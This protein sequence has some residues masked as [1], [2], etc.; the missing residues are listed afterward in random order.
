VVNG[1]ST[2]SLRFAEPVLIHQITVR[3]A[4][5][6]RAPQ[7]VHLPALAEVRVQ[8]SFL[9]SATRTALG[10]PCSEDTDGLD[11]T[12]VRM[13]N[14]SYPSIHQT[15]GHLGSPLTCSLD[16]VTLTVIFTTTLFCCHHV[17]FGGCRRLDR[18][19][20]QRCDVPR[21]H[22]WLPRLTRMLCVRI[23]NV[24]IFHLPLRQ[25]HRLAH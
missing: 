14:V 15:Y 20:L 21:I 7:P 22:C 10:L 17:V 6:G 3:C 4:P 9:D 25:R 1:Q 8:R 11:S 23:A 12:V 2:Y 13:R 24:W 19:N 16:Y 5:G 18:W